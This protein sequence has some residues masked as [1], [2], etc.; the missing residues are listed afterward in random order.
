MTRNGWILTAAMTVVALIIGF[1]AGWFAQRAAH[2]PAEPPPSAEDAPPGEPLPDDGGDRPDAGFGTVTVDLDETHDFGDGLSIRLTGFEREVEEGGVDPAT[3]EEG[4]LPYL[5]WTVELANEGS[6]TVQ[7]GLITKTCAVGDPLEESGSPGLGDSVNPP[8][9]L[10]PGQSGAWD[11]DCWLDED[12]SQIQYTVEFHDQ[13]FV[14]L[15][16]P[17]TF[18]GTVED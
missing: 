5:S 3:G 6:E 10:D 2:D 14:P 11:E 15:Y 12:D 9:S 18:T 17:V 4:D 8:E 7:T 16:P 1:G 13:D